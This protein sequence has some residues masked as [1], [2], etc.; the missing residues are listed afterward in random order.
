MKQFWVTLSKVLRAYSLEEKVLSVI[1]II[2]SLFFSFRGISYLLSPE[3]AFAQ[4]GIYTEGLLSNKPVLINPLYV[5][6]S[7]AN[8]D[9]SALVFPGLLKYDPKIKGFVDDLASLKISEDKKEYVFT[10]KENLKW[11]DDQPL[12]ADDIVFTFGIIQSPDFQNPLLKADFD[13]VGVSKIDDKTVKFSL[14][15][16][17]SFFITN[18]NVG[19]LPQHILGNVAV[20]DLISNSFNLLPIGAGPYRVAERLQ[21][22][23][24]G[25]QKVVLTKFDGYYGTKPTIQQIRFDIYPDEATLLRDKA[26][27]NIVPRIVGTLNKLIYDS[28]FTTQSY[29]LPQ[30]TAVFFNTAAEKL[31]DQKVR[32]GLIKLVD[33]DELIKQLDNKIRVDTP[34]MELNQD[35]WLNQADLN[36]ANGSLFDAGYK[37]KKDDQ[38]KVLPEEVYR[39]DQDG[40]DFSLTLLTKKYEDGSAQQ[41][42]TTEVTDFLVEAWKKGGIKIDVQYLDDAGF[43]EAIHSKQYDMILTGQSMGYNLDTFPFWH[44][45][46][47]KSDGLN[48]SNYKSF[49]ADAQIETIRSTFD[50]TNKDD[51]QKKLADIISKEVP[52]LFLYRPSYVFL[53]DGK[54]KN[55]TLEGLDYE[56]DR[57]VNV[58]DWCIGEECK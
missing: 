19:I 45:S 3:S 4:N 5:D 14:N 41:A 53:T 11:Q 12:T 31:K 33:K 48:L 26:S 13:G 46:Q 42:E 15:R 20:A 10:L 18:L 29:T 37:Y 35:D 8:R 44:S 9:V 47:A 49:A 39:K 17:N 2:L 38:G 22:T 28:R 51:R 27:L 52:A 57:F 32:V 25:K 36:Q 24:D 1:C 16:P 50:K 6:F 7:Q 30:Y 58:A 40:N 55:I 34:L 56:S 23:N 21:L 43:S 54:V